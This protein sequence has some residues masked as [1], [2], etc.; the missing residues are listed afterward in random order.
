MVRNSQ[1]K[2]D[3]FCNRLFQLYS[4]FRRVILPYFLLFSFLI[5]MAKLNRSTFYANYVDIFDLADKTRE[6]LEKDFSTL[7]RYMMQDELNKNI[8]IATS[9]IILNFLETV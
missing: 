6:N 1:E 7:F 8:L 2:D 4:P 9:N 5:K 3:C